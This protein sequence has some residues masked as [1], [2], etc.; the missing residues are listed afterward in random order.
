MGV[1][2][3]HA[4]FLTECVACEFLLLFLLVQSVFSILSFCTTRTD[5]QCFFQLKEG[6]SCVAHSYTCVSI[7]SCCFLIID[8]NLI[9]YGSL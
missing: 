6:L 4:V 5:A 7:T 2:N 3:E 1:E 9:S 8:A